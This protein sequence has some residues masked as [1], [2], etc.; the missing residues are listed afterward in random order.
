MRD[1]SGKDYWL[2]GEYSEIVPMARIVCTQNMA[3]ENG[4]AMPA[5]ESGMGESVITLMFEEVGDKT[6]LTLTQT[7]FPADEAAEMAGMGWNQAFEKLA[8]TLA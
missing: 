3:D 6:K 5:S 4:N 2:A 1:P 7:G 8:A